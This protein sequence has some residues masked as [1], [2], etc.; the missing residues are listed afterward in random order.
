MT[1][2]ENESTSKF[3]PFKCEVYLNN[4]KTLN[5]NVTQTHDASIVH[6]KPPVPSG[7]II[8]AYPGMCRSIR[9]HCTGKNAESFDVYLERSPALC[10]ALKD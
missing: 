10:C 7:E 4:V 9:I 5:L 2:F 3:N 8:T 6:I 1:Y